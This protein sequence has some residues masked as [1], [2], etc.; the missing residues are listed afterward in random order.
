[1]T[2]IAPPPKPQRTSDMLASLITQ[3][4][5]EGEISIQEILKLLGPRAFGLAVYLFSWDSRNTSRRG[6]PLLA[7]LVLLPYATGLLFV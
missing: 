3:A 4:D 6:H 7:L 5:G 1:M 2:L